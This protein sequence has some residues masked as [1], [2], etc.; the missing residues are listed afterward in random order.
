MAAENVKFQVNLK[1]ARQGLHNLYAESADEAVAQLQEFQEKVLPEILKTEELLWAG[2]TV[3]PLTVPQQAP[4][5]DIPPTRAARPIEGQ[6]CVHGEMVYREAKP[7]S[8]K[9]WKAFFCAAEK[10]DPTQ[11]KARF[12]DSRS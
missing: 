3:A 6:S 9:T 12:L 8:G 2:S 7:G 4:V 11:C 5:R 10:N 1:T